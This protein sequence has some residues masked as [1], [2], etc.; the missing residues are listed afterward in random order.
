[1]KPETRRI[2]YIIIAIVIVV[3]IVLGITLG[4]VLNKD[5]EKQDTPTDEVEPEII[6]SYNNTDELL[7]KYP[8]EN[9]VTIRP[10]IE[11]NIL[12]R[13]L[14][15]FEN[16]NRGFKAWKAWGKILYTEDSIYNVNGVRLSLA[17]YQNAMDVALKQVNIVLGVF[18]NIVVNDNYTAIY[19]DSTQVKGD[20]INPG[21]VM[22]FVLFKDYGET[23]GTRVVEGWGGTKGSS[24][25]GMTAFQDEKEKEIQMQQLNE[26]LDYDIPETSN[27]KEKYII[28]HPT[29][30]IDENAED[31]LKIV[32]EQFDAWNQDEDLA[33]YTEWV[34]NNY[35]SNATI[36]ILQKNKTLEEY[37][38]DSMAT[39]Q[40]KTIT[41]LYFDNIL[42]RD[43]WAAL[44]Y[45]YRTYDKITKEKYAGD[46]MQFLKLEQVD[47]RLIIIGSWIQ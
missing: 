10:G 9:N 45:R 8:L 12:N 20:Y 17:H 28:K 5:K 19:Y 32:Y 7:E 27:L 43:N 34:R 30:Y 3:G 4:V 1:M 36:V 21:T 38:T 11:R 33:N 42:I 37:L 22:E 14:T 46:R 15:G 31:I 40:N 26:M 23:L 16:W 13:L 29:N 44:H 18:H 6:N 24:Y 2:V 47:D 25:D 35:D 41:K 39:A